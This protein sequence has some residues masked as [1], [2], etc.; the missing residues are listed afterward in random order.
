MFSGCKPNYVLG[1]KWKAILEFQGC[2]GV[3]YFLVNLLGPWTIFGQFS[4]G[5][6]VILV[7]DYDESLQV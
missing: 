4:E 3:E 5:A 7:S 2:F 1:Y 6:D